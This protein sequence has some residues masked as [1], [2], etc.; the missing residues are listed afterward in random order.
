MYD[1][2]KTWQDYE[3]ETQ[4]H[5]RS[6]VEQLTRGEEFY[7]DLIVFKAG[8]TNAQIATALGVTEAYVIDLE[9]AVIAMHRLFQVLENSA[10]I[11]QID[12]GDN[13][14]KFT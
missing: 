5:S 12:F 11:T 3:R 10:T 1:G 7:K 4:N 14:R 8:R 13:L 6:I 2:T 9:A